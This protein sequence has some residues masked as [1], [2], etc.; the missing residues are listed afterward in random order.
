[1]VLTFSA[2]SAQRG[3]GAIGI[4]G[5]GGVPEYAA[6]NTAQPPPL[7]DLDT[8]L[9]NVSVTGRDNNAVKGI[10]QDRFHVF[11]DGVE[12]KMTYFWEDSR[13]ITVGF[14]FDDSSRMDTNDKI[15]VLKDA[16]Q[17]FLQNKDPRDEYFL[18]RMGSLADVAVSFTT[19]TKNL[20][21]NYLPTGETAL[22]DSVYVGLAVIKEA[23]NPRKLLVVITSGGDRCCSLDN[24]R[25]TEEMLKAFAL[26][27]NVEIYPVFI[28]DNVEDADSEFVHRDAIVLGDLATMTGGRMYNPGNAARMVEATMAEIARGLKTQYMVGFKSPRLPDGKRR[29]VKVR[30]DSP[31]GS[32]KLSVWTKAGYYS[33]KE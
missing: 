33:R 29:G 19:E 2:L 12:Q 30:V 10:S 1:V 28:A 23:A 20:P 5:R 15:Y 3:G 14:M 21:L 24:K 26:K 22:Y 16:A 31:E 25:T 6:T 8:V 11:E 18:V 27:Q 32:Q 4:G 7:T 17:A 13:P 9:L